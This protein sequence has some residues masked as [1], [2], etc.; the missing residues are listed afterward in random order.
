M[1]T[2]EIETELKTRA[3]AIVEDGGK[4]ALVYPH[5]YRSKRSREL[6]ASRRESA[7]VEAWLWLHPD[8]SDDEGI[9]IVMRVVARDYRLHV[10]AFLGKER[11]EPLATARRIA[12]AL[13]RELTGATL[14]II[15]DTF[16]GRDH[17]TVVHAQNSIANQCDTDDALA[18]RVGTLRAACLAALNPDN[19]P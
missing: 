4:F 7:L 11:H 16:G 1:T 3:C 13:S 17:G 8:L 15:G 10:D 5:G 9:E 19:Q 18:A 6:L 12:M 14:Q 2:A